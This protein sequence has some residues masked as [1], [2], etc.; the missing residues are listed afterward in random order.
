MFMMMLICDLVF[1][2]VYK[3]S[4]AVYWVLTR[5]YADPNLCIMSLN[6]TFTTVYL[7]VFHLKLNIEIKIERQPGHI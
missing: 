3:Y 4:L 7:N 1:V 6:E 2:L 5:S